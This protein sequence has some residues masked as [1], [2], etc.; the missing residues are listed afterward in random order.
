MMKIF[1]LT[2][3]GPLQNYHDAV[4][5]LC[6][7]AKNM[8][9]FH[10]IIGLTEKDLINDNEFWNKH[11]DFIKSNQR[12]YG[13]WLW[14]SYIIKKTLEQMNNNDILL[15]MDCGCELNHLARDDL[16]NKIEIVKTKFILGSSACKEKD[17]NKINL[18]NYLNMNEDR[19]LNTRQNAATIIMIYKNDLTTNIINEWYTICENY[20]LINDSKSNIIEHRTFIEHR[21][22]QSVFSL[23]TKKYDC[24]NYDFDPVYASNFND[25]NLFKH[26]T[27]NW[28]IWA[29]RNKTGNSILDNLIKIKK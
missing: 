28:P 20:D 5:R 7:Q 24:C 2:F 17:W 3:G 1:F 4:K 6:E 9:I 27:I 8:E 18:I 21:H 29:A 19:Y 26:N 11:S 10:E 13:Y 23:L 12:G 15:Y 22:D 25:I 16:N 14:K